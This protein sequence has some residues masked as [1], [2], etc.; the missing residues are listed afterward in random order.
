MGLHPRISNSNVH[1]S[2]L[3]ITTPT[4][5]PLKLKIPGVIGLGVSI[6]PNWRKTATGSR[7]ECN[8]SVEL[9]SDSAPCNLIGT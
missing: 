1:K 4:F 6:E 3:F 2:Q 9:I 7:T 8:A 5:R